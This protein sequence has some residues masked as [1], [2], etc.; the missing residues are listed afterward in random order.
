MFWEEEGWYSTE[1]FSN[2]YYK[3][4]ISDENNK[5]TVSIKGNNRTILALIII[6]PT[7]LNFVSYLDLLEKIIL[8]KCD[9]V[10]GIG[11]QRDWS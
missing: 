5:L 2:T 1:F 9:G 3:K 10:N 8:L 7:S 4:P 11:I 6:I